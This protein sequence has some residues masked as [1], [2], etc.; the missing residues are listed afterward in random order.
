VG[1]SRN[2]RTIA[3]EFRLGDA[4]R[5]I[6]LAG[7]MERDRIPTTVLTSSPHCGYPFQAAEPH[8]H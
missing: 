8:R 2:D 3:C 1:C 4:D 5:S 7:A 6:A